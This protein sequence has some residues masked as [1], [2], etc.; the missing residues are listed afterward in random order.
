L[1]DCPG[2]KAW[3]DSP[4]GFPLQW[5]NQASSALRRKVDGQQTS[6]VSLGI[7]TVVLVINPEHSVRNH[8]GI[9][10]IEEEAFELEIGGLVNKSVKI[11]LDD[12]K[13]PEKFP[14]V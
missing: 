12:L 9:P 6:F 13:D 4:L 5:G 7:D 8:G 2:R 11:S 10:R 14:F 1:E 3:Y